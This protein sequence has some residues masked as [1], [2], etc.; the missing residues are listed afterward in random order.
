MFL[1][2]QY[3]DQIKENGIGRPFRMRVI[4]NSYKS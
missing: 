4:K 1:A 2:K 3:H